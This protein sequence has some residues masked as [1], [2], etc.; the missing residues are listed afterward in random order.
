[1]VEDIQVS[2]IQVVNNKKFRDDS[3]CTYP[4]TNDINE[5]I[6]YVP[7]AAIITGAFKET[8][9]TAIGYG[10]LRRFPWLFGYYCPDLTKSLM[11]GH[12]IIENKFKFFLLKLVSSTLQD[13]LYFR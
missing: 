5:L 2:M 13:G 7:R 10:R 11:G 9:A 12:Y 6:E 1:M 3:C 4:I 8:I